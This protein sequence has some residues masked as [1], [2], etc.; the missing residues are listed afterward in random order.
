MIFCAPKDGVGHFSDE[1]FG[2]NLSRSH[3]SCFTTFSATSALGPLY[4]APLLSCVVDHST[5]PSL[6]TNRTAIRAS[7]I[8][9]VDAWESAIPALLATNPPLLEPDTKP[10]FPLTD[11]P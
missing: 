10:L 9:S 11:P 6:E 8:V 4:F 1:D 3:M 7:L 5:S 2:C